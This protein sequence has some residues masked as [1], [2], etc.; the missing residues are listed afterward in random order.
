LYQAVW[1]ITCRQIRK[2][3]NRLLKCHISILC[4]MRLE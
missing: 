1:C 3:Y 4:N 2:Q